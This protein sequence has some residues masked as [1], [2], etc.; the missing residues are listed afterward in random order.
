[1]VYPNNQYLLHYFTRSMQRASA[2]NANTFRSFIEDTLMTQCCTSLST[3]QMFR[4][5]LNPHYL[6]Q[7][8]RM[9][10]SE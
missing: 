10:W 5:L 1:M 3:L 6:H 2:R 4:F 8:L 7:L 9:E